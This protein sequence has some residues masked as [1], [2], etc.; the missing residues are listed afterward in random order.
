M[1]F[2]FKSQPEDFVVEEILTE[3][4]QWKGDVLYVYFEK[5]NLTTMEILEHLGRELHVSREELGIAWLK[6]KDGITSQWITV[7]KSVLQRIWGETVFC[8]SLGKITTIKKITRGETPLKIGTNQGN[9]FKIRLQIKTPLT[10]PQLEKVQSNITKIMKNGFPNCFGSQRFGKRNKNFYEAKKILFE[11]QG[12]NQYHLRF[13]LQAYASMYFNE[14]VMNRRAKG[15]FLFDGDLVVNGYSALNSNVWTYH[16]Q[17]I[18]LFDY[19]KEKE[20]KADSPFFEPDFF[21]ERIDF[22]DKKWIPTWPMIWWNLLLPEWNTKARI[23]ENQWLE[24]LTFWKEQEQICKQYQLRWIR[25][26]LRV[27]PSDF[28]SFFSEQEMTFEFT[29]P[30]GSYATTLL[31]F[32][33]EGIDQKTLKENRLEIP[34]LKKSQ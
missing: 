26:P 13:M 21:G 30:T 10:E 18:T 24:M 1:L 14:Y 5:R 29:L 6:D 7:F 15:Q 3:N 32:I 25:R 33:F 9:H 2:Q 22:E 31:S 17:K 16:Q 12:T 19:K 11:H 8:E 20:K 23:H 28:S 34:L 4:P 27:Y